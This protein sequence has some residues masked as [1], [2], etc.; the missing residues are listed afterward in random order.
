MNPKLFGWQHLTYIAIVII[1]GTASLVCFK[2][3]AKTDKQQRIALFCM[4][5]VLFGSIL[6]NRLSL[7]FRYE[8]VNWIAIIPASICGMNSLVLSLS[9]IFGKKDCPIYHYLWHL[10]LVGGGITTLCP[11]FI[12]QDVSFLYL[13]T[14]SGLLHH[15]VSV[16]VVIALLISG[17]INITYKKWHYSVIG[18]LCYITFGAFLM[19]VCG[20]KDAFSMVDPLIKNTPF[21]VWVLL[22]IYIAGYALVL[23]IIEVVRKKL[24][25]KQQ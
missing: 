25:K 16:I 1:V 10:T 15:S 7:V 4:G 14:I 5:I 18:F 20:L 3:F 9:V 6:F 24:I 21:T 8:E 19:T 13:P 22:P 2:K 23:F 17:Q 12:G 11:T